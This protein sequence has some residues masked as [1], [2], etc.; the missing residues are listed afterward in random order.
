[1][2]SKRTILLFTAFIIAFSFSALSQN[3]NKYEVQVE[4]GVAAGIA[5]S[6]G[7]YLLSLSGGY[8]ID[9]QI[10]VGAGVSYENYD[11]AHLLLDEKELLYKDT[12]RRSFWVPFAHAKYTFSSRGKIAP[13]VKGRVGYGIFGEK[14]I[15]EKYDRLIFYQAKG[16][17]NTSLDLGFSYP[18][19]GETRI[20][21]AVSYHYQRLT[22]RY[23]EHPWEYSRLQHNSSVGLN[24]G[25]LF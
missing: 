11:E 16:G 4:S 25:I 8:R 15:P 13:Y 23:L 7:L 19:V 1:M 12:G 17:I 5:K 18:L 22:N 10:T 21:L 3:L 14:R 2:N 6:T 24:V 20:L 9:S